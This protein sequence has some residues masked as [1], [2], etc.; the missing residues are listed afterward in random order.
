MKISFYDFIASSL[1]EENEFDDIDSILNWIYLLKKESSCHVDI[2]SISNLRD[3]IYKD[4]ESIF[5]NKNNFFSIE[6][7]TVSSSLDDLDNN[8]QPLIFQKE[9]GILGFIVKKI[10]GI[11]YFLVQAKIEPGNLNLIQ[12]SPTLQA[13]KSNYTLKHGGRKPDYLEYFLECSKNNILFDNLQSEQGS[14]FFKKRNRNIIINVDNKLIV[15]NN[16]KWMTLKQIKL[17]MKYDNLVNMC[18]RS[19]ISLIKFNFLEPNENKNITFDKVKNLYSD[20]SIFLKSYSGI[21]KP[22]INTEEILGLLI[23]KRSENF[24]NVKKIALSKMTNWEV[25]NDE[26]IDI[27][28][29]RFKVIGINA[30]IGS[31]E[32]FNW[33]QPMFRSLNIGIIGTI[34]K[35]FNNHL[36]IIVKIKSEIGNFDIAELGPAVQCFSES[37]K[38][39]N[40]YLK[41]ILNSKKKNILIDSYQSEEGGR[42]FQEQN[43]NIFV[44][45]DDT[46]PENLLSGYVWIDLNQLSFLNQFNN[47]VNIQLRNLIAL[48]PYH[49]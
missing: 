16:F 8:D 22:K 32:V 23:K 41:F 34:G 30:K 15:K 9:I 49:K 42:F 29:K 24:I 40:P 7:L 27:K 47:I 26:I 36:H 5:H 17:L 46:F 1:I 35:I 2:K 37:E 12:L 3:W 43:R 11:L 38:D 21:N 39:T 45:A 48:F 13:T 31:R 4:R 20:G 19:L 10:N 44:L 14:R 25:N 6:G 33:D 28:H 18:T